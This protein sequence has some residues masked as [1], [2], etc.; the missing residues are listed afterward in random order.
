MFKGMLNLYAFRELTT[1]KSFRSQSSS[2]QVISLTRP[3]CTN[4][5]PS[6]EVL[7]AAVIRVPNG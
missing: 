6:S 5:E 3:E 2:F 7:L 1:S 4:H